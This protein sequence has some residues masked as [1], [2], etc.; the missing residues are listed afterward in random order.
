M[1]FLGARPLCAAFFF[2]LLWANPVGGSG[3]EVPGRREAAS[4]TGLEFSASVIASVGA[5]LASFRLRCQAVALPVSEPVL[6]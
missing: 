4:A 5:A 2:Y 3:Q 6:R 1:H